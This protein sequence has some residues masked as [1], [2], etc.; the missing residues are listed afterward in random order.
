[1]HE[2]ADG[3][4]AKVRDAGVMTWQQIGELVELGWHIGAHTVTHPDLSKLLADDPDGEQ[5]QKELEDCDAEIEKELGIKPKDFAFTGI[6]WS[7]VAEKLVMKRYRFGRLWIIR[8][9]YHA[10][11]A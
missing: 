4:S 10:L 1:M 6:S 8:S 9:T 7:S 5:L 3:W 11:S 2:D